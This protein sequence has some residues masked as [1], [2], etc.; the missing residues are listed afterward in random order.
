MTLRTFNFHLLRI[1]LAQL[2][3]AHGFSR[4]NNRALDVITDLCVRY[5][6]LLTITILKYTTL[7]NA[8]E[9]NIQDI[10]AAFQ[11]LKII[12]PSNPLDPYD[13]GQL[14]A[15][16]IENFENWFMGEMQSRLREVARPNST[17]IEHIIQEKKSKDVNS[18]MSTLTAAL[19]QQ[20]QRAQ[21]QNPT[22]PYQYQTKKHDIIHINTKRPNTSEK[23]GNGIIDDAT[24]DG[25]WLK[26]VL[27]QQLN[28]NPELK[29]KGTVLIDY[30]PEDKRP[31]YPPK[32]TRDFYVVGPTPKN[33]QGDLPYN[34]QKEV[35][36]FDD[37]FYNTLESTKPNYFPQLNL[38]QED[39]SS[40]SESLDIFNS[41]N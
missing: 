1:T 41:D 35:H 25:D 38:D 4:C 18:K 17:F 13:M 33:L 26:F 7:R 20:S 19:D 11:E 21:Q 39:N 2:L 40:N 27:R 32:P 29:F 15:K 8:S 22:L 30:L 31:N 9:P 34:V 10:S 23:E 16:G 28:E 12:S 37:Q 24:V 14:T 3:K 36:A 6:R 5:L